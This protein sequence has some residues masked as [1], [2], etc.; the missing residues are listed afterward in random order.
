MRSIYVVFLSLVYFC[1]G[2]STASAVVVMPGMIDD[3]ETG[4]TM[5]WIKG[6]SPRSDAS[7]LPPIN[8]ANGD[9]SNRYLEVHSHGGIPDPLYRDAHSRMVFFNEAQWAGDYSQ[10]G[11]ISMKMKAVS[12]EDLYMRLAIYDS[13]PDRV[14]S[15]YVSSA[16]TILTADGEWHEISLS[17]AAEDLSRFRGERTAE[18]VLTDVAHLRILSSKDYAEAWGVDKISATLGIDDITAIAKS[19]SVTPTV[20]TVPVPA[21]IWFMVSALLGLAGISRNRSV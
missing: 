1:V 7:S 21:A 19:A 3:F 18:E 15:R 6:S 10:I 8:L 2:I 5:S 13:G 14:Y 11:S 4:T 20:T 16:P 9:E 12:T 17:L